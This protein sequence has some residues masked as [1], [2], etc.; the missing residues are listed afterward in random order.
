MADFVVRFEN[1][2]ARSQF[3]E[4]RLR[5]SFVL[6]ASSP[7][8]SVP[9]LSYDDDDDPLKRESRSLMKPLLTRPFLVRLDV[10]GVNSWLPF[11]L[12]CTELQM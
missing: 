7:G 2:H 4:L 9:V 8:L 10:T 6:V 5:R 11:L 1:G 3:G 12:S